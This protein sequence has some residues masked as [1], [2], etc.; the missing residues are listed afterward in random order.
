[1]RDSSLLPSPVAFVV[2]AVVSA[3]TCAAREAP[4]DDTIK[5][6]GDHPRYSVE[7]EPHALIGFG[8][9]GGAEG[10]GPGVRVSFPIVDNGFVSSINNSVAIGVG[11]DF[12][13]GG[14]N[15]LVFPVV[16]Q[17]NFFVA[18]QWSVFG[19]PG[20]AIFHSFAS[21]TGVE[22]VLY[23]GGRYHFNEHVSL[24]MRIGYPAVSVGLSFW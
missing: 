8:T 7:L 22:P 23:A 13:L 9:F 6:P 19:E 12:L 16:M 21:N 15:A 1:V 20:L 5:S 14:P 10:V 17:W 2:A 18:K 3:I 24:T 4:A 11:A